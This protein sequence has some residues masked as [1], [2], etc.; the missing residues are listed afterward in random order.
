MSTAPN[1][2]RVKHDPTA[3]AVWVVLSDGEYAETRELDSRRLIDVATDGA[4][5][6][7]E[8]LD[9]S[10]GV[11]VTGL[12]SAGKIAAAL[13]RQGLKIVQPAD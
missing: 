2:L 3:D 1:R 5:L 11:D 12:P 9:V 4:V 6:R 7:V 13:A 10:D 8:L